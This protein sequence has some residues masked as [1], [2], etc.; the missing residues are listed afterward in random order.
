MKE[1]LL[2]KARLLGFEVY[3]DSSQKWIIKGYENNKFWLI[4]EKEID[5]WLITFNGIPQMLVETKIA[6][7]IISN[8]RELL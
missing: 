4:E 5:R 2:N 6:L 3:Q 8:Y 1:K 7:S